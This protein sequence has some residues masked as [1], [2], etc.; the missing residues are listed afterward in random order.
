MGEVRRDS[1][2]RSAPN[3]EDLQTALHDRGSIYARPAKARPTPQIPGVR[4]FRGTEY[5]CLFFG[6]GSTEQVWLVISVFPTSAEAA[7]YYAHSEGRFCA[8]GDRISFG[9]HGCGSAG[10]L[11]ASSGRFYL[12]LSGDLHDGSAMDIQ[13]LEQ[14]ATYVFAA[15]PRYY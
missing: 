14:L 9:P 15:A 6:R 10:G 11:A 8:K 1:T 13:A 4:R 7:R 2:G 5:S 3:R 12:H